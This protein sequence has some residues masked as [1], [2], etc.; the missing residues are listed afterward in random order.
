MSDGLDDARVLV[1]DS[2]Y[3]EGSVEVDVLAAVDVGNRRA[4]RS[5]PN[6]W[7]IVDERAHPGALEPAHP[8]DDLGGT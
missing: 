2:R 4:A 5:F 7:R 3:S 6:E 1:A 8:R